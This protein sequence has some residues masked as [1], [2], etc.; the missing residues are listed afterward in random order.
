MF[1]NNANDVA[2]YFRSLLTGKGKYAGQF[3]QIV[4]AV[5]EDRN[6]T[7]NAAKTAAPTTDSKDA[8]SAAPKPAASDK[9]RESKLGMFIEKFKD[10]LTAAPPVLA[11]AAPAPAAT[12]TAAAPAPATKK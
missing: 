5:V 10:V 3:E 7:P 9:P 11:A 4:F 2:T 8:K 12:A 1:R 6:N